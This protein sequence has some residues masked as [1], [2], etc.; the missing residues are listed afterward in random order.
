M[1][2]L[3]ERPVKSPQPGNLGTQ[4]RKISPRPVALVDDGKFPPQGARSPRT[5]RFPSVKEMIVLETESR[6][7]A[8]AIPQATPGIPAT[9]SRKALAASN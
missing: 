1:F 3:L 8:A 6:R 9:D 4:K 7:R 5:G 2:D